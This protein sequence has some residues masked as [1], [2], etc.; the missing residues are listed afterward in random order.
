MVRRRPQVT[1]VEGKEKA[2]RGEDPAAP[3]KL[4]DN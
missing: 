4:G 2:P 1:D 3:K